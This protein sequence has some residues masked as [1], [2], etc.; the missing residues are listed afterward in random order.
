MNML[1]KRCSTNKDLYQRE[2]R[3]FRGGSDNKMRRMWL[4]REI[5]M[6]CLPLLP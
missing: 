3:D 4:G 6:A 5:V 1:H 2:G